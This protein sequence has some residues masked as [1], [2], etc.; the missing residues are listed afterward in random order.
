MR[1]S[2]Y[3]TDVPSPDP[4]ASVDTVL[5][6]AAITTLVVVVPF[7]VATYPVTLGAL[8]PMLSVALLQ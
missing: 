7:A 1:D 4:Q 5:G 3:S 2:S 8:V 6:V